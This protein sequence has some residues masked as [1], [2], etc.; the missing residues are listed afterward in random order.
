MSLVLIDFEQTVM[1]W[2]KSPVHGKLE[3]SIG[4]YVSLNKIT[5]KFYSY[6]RNDKENAKKLYRLPSFVIGYWVLLGD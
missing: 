4:L 3:T 5:S 2:D 1:A 6:Q